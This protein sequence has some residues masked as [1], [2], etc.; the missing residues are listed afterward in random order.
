AARGA[1]DRS[2]RRARARG[3]GG[4]VSEAPRTAHVGDPRVLELSRCALVILSGEERGCEKI[5][6]GDLFRIGKAKDNELVLADEMVLR[7]HCE[8]VRDR[9]GYLLC[10]LVSTNGTFLDG[11]EI[12]EAWLKAGAVII[13][14]KVEL[15]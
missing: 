9:C 11:A 4:L 2:C 12:K 7:A 10:D 6:E 8:I 5:I 15:K 14:G 1:R 3:A 13:V